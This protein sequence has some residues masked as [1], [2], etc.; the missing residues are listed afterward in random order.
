MLL[1]VILWTTLIQKTEIIDAKGKLI[2]PGFI[3]SHIHLLIGGARLS[4]IQMRDTSCKRLT[5]DARTDCN[6]RQ[7]SNP[8]PTN[9][10]VSGKR[11]TTLARMWFVASESTLAIQIDRALFMANRL[12]QISLT[13]LVLLIAA[14]SSA[15]EIREHVVERTYTTKLTYRCI[16]GV[17]DDYDASHGTLPLVSR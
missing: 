8:P 14:Q 11:D 10:R 2:L 9:R 16:V 5:N 15:A 1:K 13:I 6:D 4:Q 12:H 7:S 3:G 17:P